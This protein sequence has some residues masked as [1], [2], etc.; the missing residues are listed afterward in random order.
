MMGINLGMNLMSYTI[1]FSLQQITH[2]A[3]SE[4]DLT[5]A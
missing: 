3:K 5:I 2:T 4:T 1:L